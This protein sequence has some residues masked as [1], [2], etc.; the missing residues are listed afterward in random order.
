VETTFPLRNPRVQEHVQEIIDWFWRD[1]V[2]ARVL[3]ADGEYLPR[4]LEHELFDAQAE[5]LAES[6]RRRKAKPA[7]VQ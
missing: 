6:Q 7:V 1:N 2:K 4:P 3:N 5:F